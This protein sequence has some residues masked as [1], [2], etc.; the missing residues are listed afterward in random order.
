MKS[1]LV[2]SCQSF[3][4]NGTVPSLG[5]IFGLGFL[6]WCHCVILW[7]VTDYSILHGFAYQ[8]L[9]TSDVPQITIWHI[10][11]QRFQR[12]PRGLFTERFHL[13][14]CLWQGNSILTAIILVLLHSVTKGWFTNATFVACSRSVPKNRIFPNSVEMQLSAAAAHVKRNLRVSALMNELDL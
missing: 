2:W 5:I 8:S 9:F 12:R 13:S 10:T 14:G 7:F 6:F 1:E 3:G 4:T 11:T